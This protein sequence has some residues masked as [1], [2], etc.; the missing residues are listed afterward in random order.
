[1][2]DSIWDECPFFLSFSV[3]FFHILIHHLFTAAD[4][5]QGLAT[6][7]LFAARKARVYQINS[8]RFG[9]SPQTYVNMYMYTYILYIRIHLQIQRLYI[10][11]CTCIQLYD[12]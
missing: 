11:V 9:G 1:M 7:A 12:A 6:E 3:S 5:S 10:H 2:V 8:G 4:S